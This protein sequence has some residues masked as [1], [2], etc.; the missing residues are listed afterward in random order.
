M[1]RIYFYLIAFFVAITACS[2]PADVP[3][4]E[5]PAPGFRLD[6][7]EVQEDLFGAILY[8]YGNFGDSTAT[9]KVKISN[10]TIT[11]DPTGDGVILYWSSILIKVR[12]GD[13]DDDNGAGYVS[14]LSGGK[15]TNKRML[16]VWEGDMKYREP[17]EGTLEKEVTFRFALR[18]DSKT[19]TPVAYAFTPG[20]SFAAASSTALY[21]IG[22]EGA[23]PD[24]TV[25][26]AGSN[27][28]I[29][30]SP[31]YRDRVNADNNFQSEV[32]FKNRKFRI[33]ALSVHKKKATTKRT[34]A[35]GSPQ[36]Y[37]VDFDFRVEVL[38]IN[39]T[40]NIEF[41]GNTDVIKAGTWTGELH[42]TQYGLFWDPV[43][44]MSHRYRNTL[45][46]PRLEPRFKL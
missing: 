44:A 12:I 7:M 14:V 20:S 1:S 46:W 10:V 21:K 18:A 3:V 31:P 6:Y 39:D 30:W 35:T 45:Q 27:G 32:Q 28:T 25:T 17:D 22:G 15:E 24:L 29:L 9:S 16:N 4:P 40:F 36:P 34:L 2:K 26:L 5:P 38:N 33:S 42:S 13:P 43:E 8:L 11:G 23:C 19:H 37:I 41:E